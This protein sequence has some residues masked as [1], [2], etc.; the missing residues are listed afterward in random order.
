MR[1]LKATAREH[2]AKAQWNEQLSSA[3]KQ[4]PE[5]YLEWQIITVFY[6]A[7]HLVQAYLRDKTKMYP[8][9]HEERDRLISSLE[10]L[11]AIYPNYQELKHL[12]V[13][14]RYA[15]LPTN[16]FDVK[17]ARQ[18]LTIIQAHVEKLLA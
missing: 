5:Q 10:T 17:E 18:Q 9:T 16:D 3:L 8:Q 6:A 14:A 12:S 1:F 11:R 2:L 7:V 4:L 15:C 13:T